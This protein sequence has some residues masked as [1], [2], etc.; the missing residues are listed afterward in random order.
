MVDIEQAALATARIVAALLDPADETSAILDPERSLIYL[1]GLTPT[2]PGIRD[3]FPVDG[4]FSRNIEVPFPPEPCPACG[5]QDETEAALSR[6]PVQDPGRPGLASQP[7]PLPTP[8]AVAAD[9]QPWSPDPFE[10]AFRPRGLLL[11]LLILGLAGLL[12]W[13]LASLELAG[14]SPHQIA[15]PAS[16]QT[17]KPQGHAT[18]RLS[19]V[20]DSSI[21]GSEC[22]GKIYGVQGAVAL[23]IAGLSANSLYSLCNQGYDIAW[24][25]NHGQVLS[26]NS[27]Y[28]CSAYAGAQ[29]VTIEPS[30]TDGAGPAYVYFTAPE[31]P[32]PSDPPWAG[33]WN[34]TMRLT[35]PSGR[36]VLTA[37]YDTTVVS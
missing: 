11:L 26:R 10:G 5:A 28:A 36:T 33:H 34:I 15:L 29:E 9:P 23:D 35:N 18:P 21:G 6:V 2:S 16:S 19:L 24:T 22:A 3:S 32:W 17:T 12:V 30:N 7:V 8:A 27:G 25:D 20:C 1:H 14:S 31:P 13:W 4:L 37:T